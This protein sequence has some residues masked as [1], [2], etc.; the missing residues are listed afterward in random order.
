MGIEKLNKVPIIVFSICIAVN[1]LFYTSAVLDYTLI[2][3][4]IFLSIFI[5]AFFTYILFYIKSLR[6]SIDL[7]TLPYLLFTL[8]SLTS[9]YWSINTS[10]S[11]IEAS[12]MILYFTFF[13]IT[14]T[15]RNHYTDH[16]LSILLKTILILFFISAI[17]GLIQIFDLPEI[18]RKYLY[19]V[20]GNT[21][22]KNLYSS[23]I[24]L[25]SVFSV[26]SLFY[27]NK[28][29]KAISLFAIIC[30]L[31]LICLLQTRAVW[32]GYSVFIGSCLILFSF[33]KLIKSVSYK[34]LILCIV[35]SIILI[36]IFFIFALPRLI[37]IYNK[38][39][40]SSYNLEN[41]TDLA[42]MSERVLVWGKTYEVFHNHPIVG[43]GANNWQ[44]AF[45][46]YSLPDIYR[47]KD[48]NVTF[49]RPHN[50]FLWILSEYGIIG[51][52]LYFFFIVS[53]L[54]FL[55][56]RLLN[57]Y[58]ITYVILIS[59]I[60]GYFCISF[61]DFPKER[62]EHNIL[63]GIL[64]GIAY[65]I[66]SE[67]KSNLKTTLFNIPKFALALFI[68][69]LIV[70]PY[71]AFL[72]LEGEY[73]TKKIYIERNRNNN[74][75]VIKLCSKAQ[76]FC[77][78]LDPTSVP[79]SW[80][81]G[82]AYANLENY[83]TALSAF[84]IA[85][86]DHPFNHYVLNDMGSSYYMNNKI[87]SAKMFYMESAEINP[88]FDDPKLNLT[89]IFINEDNYI[90]AQKWNESIFHDS[91][92]RNYYRSLIKEKKGIIKPD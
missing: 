49:Q 36:N 9:N 23:F 15:L 29:W 61:F 41:V 34:Y 30:Q 21:G 18:S 25:C 70:I 19:L 82:N 46:S 2:P 83:A 48:L 84:R 89:A 59:G 13:I 54:F 87:D 86:H 6:L 58:R 74:T 44:I 72:N 43:V 40:P 60:I 10:L 51:F 39:K 8:F 11:I 79:I 24:F 76:S 14:I 63:I 69:P 65:Y 47:V 56:F 20:T 45:T 31:V 66:I 92:R 67:E 90:E 42:T 73:Y 37:N 68:I 32:I 64:L 5:L 28:Y 27:L 80:Y 50:D 53:M 22:H 16:F 77:Y 75:E 17:Q 91:E 3:R 62:I 85:Y 12:K 33:H 78:T 1:C 57:S 38:H 52:N 35:S 7:I 81:K 4:F 26:F 88:R 55:L 71:F